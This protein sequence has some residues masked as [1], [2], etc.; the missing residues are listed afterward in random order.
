MVTLY[1]FKLYSHPNKLLY[2][3]LHEVAELS[4]KILREKV[5]YDESYTKDLLS[6]VAYLIGFTHDFGKATTF[7]QNHLLGRYSGELAHHSQISSLFTYYVVKAYLKKL[8]IEDSI[9]PLIAWIVVF[10]HHSD[11]EDLLGSG[12]MIERAKNDLGLI[13]KQA[14]DIR[15]KNLDEIKKIYSDLD[16]I[17]VEKFLNGEWRSAFNEIRLSS[18]KYNGLLKYYFLTILLYSTLLDADKLIASGLLQPPSRITIIND[19]LVDD[20][21][22]KRQIVTNTPI[23]Q[24]RE[25]AYKEVLENMNKIDFSKNKIFTIELPTGGGKTLTAL[26]F[27]LKLRSKILRE[28]GFVPKIVYCLPFLSIIDQTAEVTRDLLSLDYKD[29]TSNLML[30]H[31]H[32]SD[33][34]YKT[35]EGTLDDPLKSLLLIEGWHSEII[36]TTFVQ[37]FHSLITNKNSSS[38]KFHNM[39]NSIIILDEVQTIPHKYWNVLSEALKELTKYNSWIILMTATMPLIFK[40]EEIQSLVSQRDYYY[41]ELDRVEYNFHLEEMMLDDFNKLV[42]NDI[43]STNKD[44]MIVLNTISSSKKT[45]QYI[46]EALTKF[47]GEPKISKEGI[48]EYKDLMLVY[49]SSN[50]IPK[51]RRER[52]SRIKE[53]QKRKI[54]VSTQ[55]VE[56]GIDISVDKIYRDFAPLDSIIQTAGRC[57]RHNEKERGTVNIYYLKDIKN[58]KPIYFSY[59]VY[60]RLLLEITREL[61]KEYS[62]IKEKDFNLKIIPKYYERVRNEGAFLVRCPSLSGQINL[63]EMLKNLRFTAIDKCF[64]LIEEEP[65]KIDVFVKIDE[66]SDKIFRKISSILENSSNKEKRRELLAIRKEFFDYV[67]SVDYNDLNMRKQAEKIPFIESDQYDIETGFKEKDGHENALII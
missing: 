39:I 43:L 2:E 61:L 34:N 45:Y 54:I 60:D 65:Y 51:H 25:R 4:R 9:I 52:I 63:T 5:F 26:A 35:E 3:H 29:V 27:A 22:E 15:G 36:I 58:N 19:N 11:L 1:S 6:E 10:R 66:D 32:L 33:V 31:H 42:V 49:L 62:S 37:F 13:E 55:V 28:H 12:S 41:K 20:Y 40:K 53:S 44:I 38:R 14:N 30:M 24:L 64:K 48:A 56:A 17:D 16:F 47:L 57:N 59:Q 46:R 8:K 7:F 23:S 18:F 21:K 50:I 67:I